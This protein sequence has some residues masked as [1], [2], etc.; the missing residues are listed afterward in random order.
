MVLENYI[1]LQEGIPARLHFADHSIQKRTITDP[2]TG[3]PATRNVLV[4]EVDRLNYKEVAAKYS[5]MAEK[6]AGQFGPY[7]DGKAY[8]DYDFVITQTGEGF[9][10]SWSVQVIPT[11][12]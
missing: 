1:I 7:L 12:T 4:F 3:L 6:H 2:V 11:K 5:T 10:R 9:R 8:R